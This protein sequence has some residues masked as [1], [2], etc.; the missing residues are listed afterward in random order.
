MT[1]PERE[2]HRSK[3]EI[4]QRQFLSVSAVDSETAEAVSPERPMARSPSGRVE[5]TQGNS[6]M[7][8]GSKI[9]VIPRAIASRLPQHSSTGI[10]GARS[11][12]PSV[13]PGPSRLGGGRCLRFRRPLDSERQETDFTSMIQLA[14]CLIPSTVT[15]MV[16]GAGFDAKN[17]SK[18]KTGE[19][20]A[21]PLCRDR[22]AQTHCCCLG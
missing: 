1:S 13:W 3:S 7:T 8:W 18:D 4:P 15:Q 2:R 14:R 16:G 11:A 21:L 22:A 5:N 17:H 12:I 10:P 9:V 19:R 20:W 6:A